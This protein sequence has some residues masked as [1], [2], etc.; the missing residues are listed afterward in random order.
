M[1]R[2]KQYRKTSNDVWGP[3]TFEVRWQYGSEHRVVK[4]K[5]LVDAKTV[6]DRLPARCCGRLVKIQE[7]DKS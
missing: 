3:V 6:L 1:S 7:L 2:R 5:N 4:R